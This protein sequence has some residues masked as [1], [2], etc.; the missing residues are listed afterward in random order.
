MNK[1]SVSGFRYDKRYAG[2]LLASFLATLLG[3]ATVLLSLFGA[4]IY[5]VPIGISAFF[6]LITIGFAGLTAH[7][8]PRTIYRGPTELDTL[9]QGRFINHI[10]G[11][12]LVISIIGVNVLYRLFNWNVTQID[13]LVFFGFGVLV[14]AIL[15][16][17]WW[18]GKIKAEIEWRT[19]RGS[20]KAELPY[21]VSVITR[22]SEKRALSLFV[23]G[24]ILVVLI[25]QFVGILTAI[26]TVAGIYGILSFPLY[27]IP[28]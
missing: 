23:G 3:I 24:V 20:P 12:I 13:S 17:G 14:I 19:G 4:G 21:A 16:S 22:K 5:G 8:I 2:W 11:A 9:E 1:R 26:G 15:Y 6:I 25:S 28:E 18:G 10:L 7:F 27:F